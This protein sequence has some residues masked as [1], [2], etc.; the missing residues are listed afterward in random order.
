MN[1]V[2]QIS[3]IGASL[4]ILGLM[5]LWFMMELLVRLTT[6]K[7]TRSSSVSAPST[8][9]QQETLYKQKAAAAATA[10]T[11]ALLKSS[12]LPSEQQAG[13][14]LSAWQSMNRHSQI[15]N[16]PNVLKK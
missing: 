12:F 1:K 4:V 8:D 5:L 6:K 7:V 3:L 11:I 2:L 15:Q 14:G 16:R 13:Q 10:V 9:N